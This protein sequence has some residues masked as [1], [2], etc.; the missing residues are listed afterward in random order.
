MLGRLFIRFLRIGAF[1]FGGGYAM[2]SLVEHEA[3]ERNGW[4]SKEE[5]DDLLSLA[6]SAPGP[7]AL[8]MAVFT[9]YRV[10]GFKGA[11]AAMLGIVIPSFLIIL[12][13]AACLAD[14][15]EYPAIEAAFKGMR[16]AVVAL[17]AAPIIG[18]MRGMKW[19]KIAIAAAIA[20]A[21]WMVGISPVLFIILGIVAG[22]GYG[23][24]DT[25]WRRD[26]Q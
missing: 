20:A 14:F 13:I 22:V 24:W 4:L 19:W 17:I 8:N 5:F 7:I 9:G 18:F 12:L 25:R 3:V 11:V 26:G 23:L 2:I 21:I 16:P 15:R 1:T 10:E 6:Q